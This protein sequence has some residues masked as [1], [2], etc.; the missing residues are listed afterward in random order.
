MPIYQA[1]CDQAQRVPRWLMDYKPG[2]AFPR[3][4]FFA[5]RI[6]FYPGSGTDGQPIRYFGQAHAVHCYVY[7]DYDFPEESVVEQLTDH[8]RLDHPRGYRLIECRHL[9]EDE[10]TPRGWVPHLPPPPP[11][12]H[13]ANLR[14]QGGPFARWAVLERDENRSEEYGP[15]RWCMLHIGGDGIATFDALFCQRGQNLPFA[16][17][18]HDHGY[19]LNYTVFGGEQSPLWRLIEMTGRRPIEWILAGEH[20]DV[21]PGYQAVD[22][23]VYPRETTRK[24]YRFTG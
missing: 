19:G 18:L 20:T 4:A 11:D 9:T 6:L 1:L 7:A 15:K 16:L 24:L 14:P 5:S 22:E 13:L 3:Q 10:I 2:D 8:E 21:W 23:V 17:L 12:N